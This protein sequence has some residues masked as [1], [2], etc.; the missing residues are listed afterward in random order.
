ME[1]ST[2]LEIYK[3]MND[4]VQKEIEEMY[5]VHRLHMVSVTALITICGFAYQNAWLNFIC[6][7]ASV[8]ICIIWWMAA[9][10][11][12]KW[13]LWW[14]EQL[15]IV[16]HELK[17]VS[18]WKKLIFN[19]SSNNQKLMEQLEKPK[20]LE[21]Q[22]PRIRSVDFLLRY[23]PVIFGFIS[24]LAICYGAHG[25]LTGTTPFENKVDSKAISAEA[26]SRAA[27]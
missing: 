9:E 7:T 25:M 4:R 5:D 26:K 21:H 16:E 20:V 2:S 11:Q 19:E 12:E 23:R 18:I 13:K 24:F 17:G 8:F 3:I 27:E 1:E 15:A 22:P 10:A 14:T 6:G